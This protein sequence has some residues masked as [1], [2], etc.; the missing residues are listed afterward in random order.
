MGNKNESMIRRPF[1]EAE[2]L[3]CSG[4]NDPL[5]PSSFISS[6]T[7]KDPS[8]HCVI[9]PKL[10]SVQDDR[11]QVSGEDT[12]SFIYSKLFFQFIVIVFSIWLP[13]TLYFP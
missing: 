12:V 5:C 7:Q 3:K 10:E 9:D 1:C 8:N 13:M 6:A 4:N 2:P 11:V